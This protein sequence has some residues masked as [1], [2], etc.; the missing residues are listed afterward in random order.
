MTATVSTGQ[1]SAPDNDDFTLK[2]NP[3]ERVEHDGIIIS[4]YDF[5]GFRPILSPDD[6]V[7]YVINFWATWCK[8][9][10]EEIPDFLRLKDELNSEKVRFLFVSLDFRRNLESQVVPFIKSRGMEDLVSVLHDPDANAWIPQVYPD[11]S[12]A[13][14]ATLIYRDEK[15]A[16]YEKKLHYEELK[17]IV[18]SFIH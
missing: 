3:K 8:P 10:V 5:E 15:R 9:C 7:T 12:G 1:N 16:F 17:S 11:W 18:E 6:D 14:P 4:V 2:G 13:I